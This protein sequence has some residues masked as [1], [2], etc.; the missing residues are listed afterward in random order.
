MTWR[1]WMALK[2]GIR[3]DK[4]LRLRLKAYRETMRMAA[5]QLKMD[6]HREAEETLRSWLDRTSEDDLP[7]PHEEEMQPQER[8]RRA[9]G[10]DGMAAPGRER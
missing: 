5:A 8:E 4:V 10:R 1:D 9:A 3:S 6:R 7:W 2:L